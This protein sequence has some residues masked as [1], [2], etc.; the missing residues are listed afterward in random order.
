[1]KTRILKKIINK[2]LIGN[3]SEIYGECTIKLFNGGTGKKHKTILL[4]KIIQKGDY[5]QFNGYTRH[6]GEQ[7]TIHSDDVETLEGMPWKKFAQA[8]GLIKK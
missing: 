1:M 3:N 4:D 8:Y 6:T 2:K 7:I 5:M